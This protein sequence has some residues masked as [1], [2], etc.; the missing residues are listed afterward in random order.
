MQSQAAI[1]RRRIGQV[2]VVLAVVSALT[3]P[4][5]LGAVLDDSIQHYVTTGAPVL[6]LGAGMG[7]ILRGDRAFD[8]GFD[9][10][11]EA[12]TPPELDDPPAGNRQSK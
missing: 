10:W 7:L 9:G 4:F 5:L 3:L 8:R 12:E 1:R 6:L 11:D 2:L